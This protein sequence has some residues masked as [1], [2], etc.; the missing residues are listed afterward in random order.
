MKN[1]DFLKVECG[2]MNDLDLMPCN[3][4]PLITCVEC[5]LHCNGCP[6]E[7]PYD[8]MKVL[9]P[10]KTVAKAGVNVQELVKEQ[11]PTEYKNFILFAFN[12]KDLDGVLD[13]LYGAQ[14]LLHDKSIQKIIELIENNSE[15]LK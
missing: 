7:I 6:V 3:F 10:K 9:Y 5:P 14:E 13:Y 15:E 1:V 4:D 2:R 8:V 12:W 11:Y